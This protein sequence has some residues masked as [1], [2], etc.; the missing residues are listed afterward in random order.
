[1]YLFILV[2]L[3]GKSMRKKESSPICWPKCL[4]RLL[5]ARSKP[6][7]GNQSGFPIGRQGCKYLNHHP[8]SFCLCNSKKLGLKVE[9][10]YNSSPLIWEVG[11]SSGI[12]TSVLSAWKYVFLIG[13]HFPYRMCDYTK[14]CSIQ[15]MAEELMNTCKLI[16]QHNNFW[17]FSEK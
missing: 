7:I 8:L 13:E 14:M 1:M 9:L 4:Q 6:G 10:G 15:E 11:I 3:K 16:L 17:V 12:L 2:Y 5:Q